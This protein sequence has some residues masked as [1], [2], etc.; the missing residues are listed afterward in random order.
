MRALSVGA[1]AAVFVLTSVPVGGVSAAEED[2]AGLA[3]YR[4]KANAPGLALE[5]LYRD[6][7]LTVPEATS[8]LTT[9]GVGTGFAS[10]AWPGPVIGNGGTTLLVLNDSV[11]PE[12]TV[13]NSPVRA[14]SHS[15]ATE[16]ASNGTVPGTT[17]RSTATRTS[18]SA[19]SAMG[20]G[21]TLPVGGLDGF[22]AS[23][24]ASLV[25]PASVKATATSVVQD[26]TLAGGVI[27][28]GSVRSTASAVSDGVKGV[29]TGGTTVSGM[30]VAGV[31]VT[32]DG[33]GLHVA[34]NDAANPVADQTLNDAIAALGLTALLTTPRVVQSGSSASY[35]AGALVL[36]YTQA[37][38]QYALTIGRASVAVDATRMDS[39]LVPELPVL[40]PVAPPPAASA[41]SLPL[42]PAAVAGSLPDVATVAPP[43]EVPVTSQPLLPAALSAA[44]PGGAPGW[45]LA[46][47]L[48]A[49]AL[50]GGLLPRLPRLLLTAPTTTACEE[51]S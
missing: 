45:L 23:T 46:L 44:L 38:S 47:V 29:A 22:R 41:P 40:P 14:E 25:G 35:D 18:A 37:D 42:P 32:V 17:M 8:S 5:G 7:A 10:L 31:P 50:L 2:G 6:V 24:T 13:L 12:A 26:L 36:V 21:T 33:Q 11:P 1:A 51:Q 4:L 48:G 16:S 9:G 30:T 39:T 43:V 20:S 19:D 27:A 15:G 49:V 34:G 3:A 28:I